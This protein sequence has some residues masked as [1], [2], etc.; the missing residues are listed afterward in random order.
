MTRRKT[1]L[2]VYFIFLLSWA[3]LA[4][5]SPQVNFLLTPTDGET[6][7][8]IEPTFTWSP[9]AGASFYTIRISTAGGANFDANVIYTQTS[10]ATTNVHLTETIPANYVANPAPPYPVP[11]GYALPLSNDRLYYWQVE[12]HISGT[13][14]ISD[15]WSFRTYANVNLSLLYPGTN[16]TVVPT[17]VLFSYFTNVVNT[18]FDFKLE[19]IAATTAP[20]ASDGDW[21]TL[22]INPAAVP[23]ITQTIPELVGGTK[24]YWRVVLLQAGTDKILKY[25]PVSYFNTSGGAAK[26]T[27]F[28]PLSGTVYTNTPTLYW[29]LGGFSTDLT[30]EVEVSLTNGAG[31]FVKTYP[32][33]G[34]PAIEDLYFEIPEGGCLPGTKYYW[35]VRSVY[36]PAGGPVAY[37]DPSPWKNFTTHG[38]G[39]VLK[40]T[41]SYPKG[42]TTVYSTVP[43]LFWYVGG[44]SEGLTFDVEIVKA[45]DNF[46]GTAT[47]G[48][49]DIEG[50][51]VQLVNALE[52]GVQYKWK[53]CAKNTTGTVLWSDQAVF[54]VTG[55]TANTHAVVM[56]P[57]NY[58]TLYTKKPTLFWYLEGAN[59]GVTGYSV[60][61]KLKT[62]LNWTTLPA[63][64]GVDNISYEFPADI[65]NC[66][67]QKYDWRVAAIHGATIGTYSAGSFKIVA[68]SQPGVPVLTY[69]KNTTV[70]TASPT[71]FWYVNGSTTNVTGYNVKYSYSSE[72]T[73]TTT[74]TDVTTDQFYLCENL[75]DGYT[76]WW[77]VQLIVDG[78]AY[79]DYSQPQKFY[80]K[81]GSDAPSSPIVGGPDNIS[82]TTTSPTI[83]WA[84]PADPPIGATYDLEIADNPDFTNALIMDN[85]VNQNQDVQGLIVN[86]GYFWR[87]RMKDGQGN[88]SN[89]S[90]TAQ[91]MVVSP[92]SIENE[93]IPSEFN[94][95]QNYPNPF[96]PSTTIRFNLPENVNVKLMVFNSLGEQV[97]QLINGQMEA[98]TY[99]IKFDANTLPS[100]IYFYR[101]EAGSFTAIRKM[102]L[103]K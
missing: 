66:E 7:I 73:P 96:N 48:L 91:F 17:E 32:A 15:I 90:P 59:F 20:V 68:G 43:Y 86:N 76:Y 54:K 31:G 75:H 40:P 69:P 67:G 1:L 22:D 72:F 6:G 47:A 23:E 55:G 19:G 34:D 100:G 94:L 10:I 60:Q 64:V 2:F 62:D 29:Y 97:S 53:V 39:T 13:N 16:A 35:R 102:I 42:N 81:P 58:T 41:C 24:Y 103:M 98:G 52:P 63:V 44:T 45:S 3:G 27:P 92:T 93:A 28:Y 4:N 101:I 79:G 71:L 38:V 50:L 95:D 57:K 14:P 37:S 84:V 46:T 70:Y 5:P 82:V 83:S 85:L 49:T 78:V 36:T 89:Y 11:T 12:A 99:S 25:S 18:G 51:S 9:V 77:K 74:V 30:F 26:P 8:S 21:L 80:V 88:H 87:V 61:Y 65:P 56:Y 33:I